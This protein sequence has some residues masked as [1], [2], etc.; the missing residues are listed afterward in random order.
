[1][2][3]KTAKKYSGTTKA[4]SGITNCGCHFETDKNVVKKLKIH[5]LNKVFIHQFYEGIYSKGEIM[6]EHKPTWSL[7]GDRIGKIV[8]PSNKDKQRIRTGV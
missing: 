2:K 5:T 8:M 4:A 1:M 7:R 3:D 6:V